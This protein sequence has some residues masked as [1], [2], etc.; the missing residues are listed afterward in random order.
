MKAQTVDS[1]GIISYTVDVWHIMKMYRVIQ[2]EVYA[3]KN[4][5]YLKTTDAKSMPCVRMER[6]SL[7][8]LI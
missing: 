2:K 7:K 5:F 1:E 6:K 3:F 4:L 8:I